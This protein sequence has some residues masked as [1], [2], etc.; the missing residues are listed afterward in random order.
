MDGLLDGTALR[1]L[2]P[3][4]AIQRV[5]QV[6]GLGPFAAELVVLRGANAPT[7]C[8]ATNAGWTPRSGSDTALAAASPRCRRSGGR[9]AP[10]PPSTCVRCATRARAR[11]PA[12]KS[13]RSARMRF[14]TMHWIGEL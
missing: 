10:G 3:D 11:S 13:R 12:T 8:P 7:R 1:A 6:K 5:Q 2:D 9:T 14:M 4:Q